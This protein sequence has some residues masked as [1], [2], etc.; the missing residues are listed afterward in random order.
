MILSEIFV[1]EDKI[2][3]AKNGDLALEARFDILLDVVVALVNDLD[4]G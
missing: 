3:E 4:E 1:L 2:A